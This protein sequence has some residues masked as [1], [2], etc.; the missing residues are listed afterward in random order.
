M[1]CDYSYSEP[2][3]FITI[4]EAPKQAVIQLVFSIEHGVYWRIAPRMAEQ[5]MNQ[6]EMA[7]FMGFVELSHRIAAD[8]NEALDKHGSL[9]AACRD[10]VEKINIVI[11]RKAAAEVS[12]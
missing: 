7:D 2:A 11:D 9:T 3:H 10:T 4:G 12:L 5:V 1:I 8:V 6:H